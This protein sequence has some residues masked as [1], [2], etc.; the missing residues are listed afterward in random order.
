MFLY[1]YVFDVHCRDA[2]KAYNR[3]YVKVGMTINDIYKRVYEQYET[4]NM[5]PPRI[6]WRSEQNLTDHQ[7]HRM[8]LDK[9]YNTQREWFVF[10]VKSNELEGAYQEVRD[11]LDDLVSDLVARGVTAPERSVVERTEKQCS[12]DMEEA[13][14]KAELA[15]IRKSKTDIAKLPEVKP[16]LKPIAVVLPKVEAITVTPPVPV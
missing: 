12:L 11:E 2:L 4:S 3:V 9:R 7:L 13:R 16:K 1:G 8:M 6:I 15:W 14:L 10:Y 5:E